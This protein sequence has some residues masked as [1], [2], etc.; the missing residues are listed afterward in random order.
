MS[1]AVFVDNH[2]KIS[3]YNLQ[4]QNPFETSLI[5]PINSLSLSLSLSLSGYMPDWGQYP[6]I[7]THPA[8]SLWL[9]H[10]ADITYP[11]SNG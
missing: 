7:M 8:S 2:V 4:P 1:Y 6:R 10:P 9:C 5:D 11:V 3:P